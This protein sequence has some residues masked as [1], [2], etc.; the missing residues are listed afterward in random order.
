MSNHDD[1]SVL[2]VRRHAL[3]NAVTTLVPTA[4]VRYGWVRG[5]WRTDPL[6]FSTGDDPFVVEI[7]GD[8]DTVRLTGDYDLDPQVGAR[9]YV[10]CARAR[11]FPG[12][13]FPEDAAVI[14][15]EL[16]DRAYADDVHAR[17][18]ATNL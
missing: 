5:D 17:H 13:V 2:L 18:L 8:I 9:F 12:Y 3:H 6:G 14:V 7:E 11:S 10:H 1:N 15:A 16:V 4:N